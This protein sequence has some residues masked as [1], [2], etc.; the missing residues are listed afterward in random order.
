MLSPN[1]FN[2]VFV[3][4]ILNLLMLLYKGFLTLNLPGAFGWSIISLT[5]LVRLV[6]HP[7]FRQQLETAK[8]IQ[9]MKPHLD[10]LSHK[11]K[12]DPKKLQQEQLRLYQEAGINPASGCVFMIIQ[13][14]IFIALYNTL[15]LFLLNGGAGKIAASINKILYLPWLRITSPIDPWFFGFDLV[16]SPAKAKIWFY[17]LI[18]VVTAFLQYL[19]ASVTT[20]PA[21][22]SAEITEKN[23]DGKEDNKEDFQKMMNTQM[24]FVFPL[25]IGWFS[26]S[27]PVGLSVYWN[28]FSVFSI[29]QY[30]KLKVK[31]KS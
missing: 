14:P 20:P 31:A 23:K 18:P 19:Q 10:K 29:V 17:Y 12:S 7:F 25:M 21:S 13:I 9:D 3:F 6:L 28:L 8:K 26:Y 27:L 2:T 22:T 24:K 4:P 11:H 15:S 5:L 16:L 30:K 1:F